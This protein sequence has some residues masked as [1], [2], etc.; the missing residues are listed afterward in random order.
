MQLEFA[1]LT[2]KRGKVKDI[3]VSL[4][5]RHGHIDSHYPSIT[6][7]KAV[8]FPNQ[9]RGENSQVSRKVHI[10]FE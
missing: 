7:R 3:W 8:I 10:N 2:G 9:Q 6:G 1:I 4:H 5:D